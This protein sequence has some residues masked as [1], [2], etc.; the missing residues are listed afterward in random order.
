VTIDN[1]GTNTLLDQLSRF[2][3]YFHYVIFC[4]YFLPS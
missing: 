3:N 2:H 4:S 1:N